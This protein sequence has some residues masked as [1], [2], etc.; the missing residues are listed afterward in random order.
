MKKTY[1]KGIDLTTIKQGD[2]VWCKQN[3]KSKIEE[4]VGQ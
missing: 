4:G 2:K 1:V 3:E